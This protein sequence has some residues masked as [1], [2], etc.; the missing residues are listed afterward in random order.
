MRFTTTALCVLSAVALAGWTP[1]HNHRRSRS[2]FFRNEESRMLNE[3]DSLY[4]EKK[5]A[6]FGSLLQEDAHP[7]KNYLIISASQHAAD[8]LQSLLDQ[9]PK[10]QDRGETLGKDFGEVIDK[11]GLE[12]S[13][14]LIETLQRVQ[15]K[16]A[17]TKEELNVAL[18]AAYSPDKANPTASIGFKWSPTN[19]SLIQAA[20]EYIISKNVTTIAMID[21]DAINHCVK[22]ALKRKSKRH[23]KTIDASF[24]D[25]C[26]P[27]HFEGLGKLQ[28]GLSQI[29]NALIITES[30]LLESPESVL[31]EIQ[32]RLGVA[33]KTPKMMKKFEKYDADA[34]SA[35][36]NW[37]EVNTALKNGVFSNLLN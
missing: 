16:K 10:I 14:S 6:K 21:D 35:V 22:S 12:K 31:D 9:H 29:P 26:V 3:I 17:M 30:E 18:E 33:N 13:Y 20:S 25:T 15:D 11:L 8:A 37:E 34:S 32:S 19:P 1:G 27:R 28:R 24:F 5:A 23:S 2:K 36:E 4:A 7:A